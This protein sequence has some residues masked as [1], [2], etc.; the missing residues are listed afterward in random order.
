M[1]N[2]PN[3]DN[4]VSASDLVIVE[5]AVF[6]ALEHFPIDT[7]SSETY[8]RLKELACFYLL[9]TPIDEISRLANPSCIDTFKL[10]TN[11]QNGSRD[12]NRVAFNDGF[13]CPLGLDCKQFVFVYK[14]NEI[15][16]NFNNY[17]LSSN[18]ATVF[19]S[20]DERAV[21][22]V[23]KSDSGREDSCIESICRHIRN[24]LGHGRVSINDHGNEP[25]IFLE[26]GAS[27]RKVDYSDG[28]KSKNP[29]LELRMRML[30]KLSTLERWREILEA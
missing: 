16:P 4:K 17:E 21:V 12:W 30:I 26:D 23:G 20:T 9:R 29:T 2:K 8:E 27:P 14:R 7:L 3:K 10:S 19:E 1:D 18:D 28:C 13:I 11:P 6:P 5:K 22:F 25:Y 15:K 24:A